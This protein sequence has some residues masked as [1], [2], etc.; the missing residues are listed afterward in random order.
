[1]SN[2][3]PVVTRQMS[4]N[5]QYATPQQQ[6][7]SAK[8]QGTSPSGTRSTLSAMSPPGENGRLRTPEILSTGSS[9][10]PGTTPS[11]G[12]TKRKS[13]FGLNLK[14]DKDELKLPKEFLI[15]FWG[16]LASDAGDAPWKASVVNFLANIKKGTKTQSGMNLREV[17][18]LLQGKVPASR[19]GQFLTFDSVLS[20]DTSQCSTASTSI[21]LHRSAR[22]HSTSLFILLTHCSRTARQ[23]QRP[24]VPPPCR[25]S[26]I[27]ATSSRK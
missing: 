15:E 12:M 24:H 6:T 14:K 1:M 5:N 17:P 21:T 7:P 20:G 9:P 10:N 16:V 22:Q 3:P 11:P 18:V 8:L 26:V 19:N 27:F 2:P 13:S 4:V 25:N 23:G